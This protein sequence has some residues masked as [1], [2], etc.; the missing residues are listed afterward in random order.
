MNEAQVIV[1][2]VD[3]AIRR[4]YEANEPRPEDMRAGLLWVLWHHQGASSV[5]GQAIR[6]L[7]HIG[8]FDRLTDAQVEDAKSFAVK[9]TLP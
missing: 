3:G 1:N 2:A 7:L 8:K 9:Y 6:K 5:T 4:L